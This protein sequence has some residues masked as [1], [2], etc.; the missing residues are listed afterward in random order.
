MGW[1]SPV[2]LKFKIL[3]QETW[4]RQISW[5]ASLPAELVEEWKT[6]RDQLE[7]LRNVKLKRYFGPG[8]SELFGF[9]DASQ[10]AYAAV[11]YLR[12]I[13]PEGTVSTSL[14]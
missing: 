12:R 9:A 14:L 7:I 10:R 11:V 13:S 4:I 5:D 6:M 1:V 2:T 8:K 3:F